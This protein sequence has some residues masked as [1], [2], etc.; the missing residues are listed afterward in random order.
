[1]D[2]I[3]DLGGDLGMGGFAPQTDP[4]HDAHRLAADLSGEG[5]VMVRSDVDERGHHRRRQ[6]RRRPVVPQDVRAPLAELAGRRWP[7]I[8]Q[9]PRAAHL[10]HEKPDVIAHVGHFQV[11]VGDQ[12][13]AVL[14]GCGE[15]VV[16]VVGVDRLA[17]QRAVEPDHQVLLA[18]E[19]VQEAGIAQPGLLRDVRQQSHPRLRKIGLHTATR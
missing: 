8:G 12:A 16:G 3:D 17:G 7:G 15:G 13:G 11:G 5:H 2:G 4:A 1:L 14:I 10:V 9:L 18:R 6:R 19:V